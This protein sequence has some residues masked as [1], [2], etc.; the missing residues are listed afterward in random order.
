MK[1][2]R[3]TTPSQ[4]SASKGRASSESPAPPCSPPASQ[5][6]Q[7][8]AHQLLYSR[9]PYLYKSP[10]LSPNANS[11]ETPSSGHVQS[12]NVKSVDALFLPLSSLFPYYCRFQQDLLD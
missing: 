7:A 5:A 12:N 10:L 6:S 3:S 11:N 4:R 9:H 8:S 1:R 2:T